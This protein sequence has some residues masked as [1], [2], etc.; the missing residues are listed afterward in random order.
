MKI[1]EARAIKHLWSNSS[2]RLQYYKRDANAMQ[3]YGEQKYMGASISLKLRQ[4]IA[5]YKLSSHHLA[6]EEER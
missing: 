4:S 5:S 2:P 1:L 6:V 3:V